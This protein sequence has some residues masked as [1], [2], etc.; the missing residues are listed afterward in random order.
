[1]RI[2]A[3][4][5]VKDEIELIDRCVA[6]LRTIEVDAIIACDKGSTDGTRERLDAYRADADFTII[7]ISDHESHDIWAAKNLALLEHIGADWVTFLDADEFIV[8]ASGRLDDCAALATADIVTIDRFN[9]PLAATGPLMPDELVPARYDDLLV[10][11]EPITDYWDQAEREPETSWML[12]K[13]AARVIARSPFIGTIAYGGHNVFPPEGSAPARRAHADDAFVAHAPTTTWPRFERKVE[14]IREWL[15]VHDESFGS[16][17]ALHWRRWAAQAEAGSLREEF[18]RLVFD[19]DAISDM[20]SR[21]I[22]R[23]A[24]E[25]FAERS[26]PAGA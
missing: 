13:V 3:V 1:M 10:V 22:I 24:R 15:T 26:S 20:L 23:S 4:V 12:A 7:E 2:A 6:H 16:S 9:V 11:A 19:S 18:D 25:I 17:R 5:S 8:T 14:N 21:S